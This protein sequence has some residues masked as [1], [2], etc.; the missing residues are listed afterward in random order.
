MKSG[1]RYDDRFRHAQSRADVGDRASNRHNAE[2]ADLDDIV[3]N[4]Y[5]SMH[6]SPSPNSY[7]SRSR[8]R[9][10]DR[11]AWLNVD[12]VQPRGRQS[13]EYSAGREAFASDRQR[14]YRRLLKT[15]PDIHSP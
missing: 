4:G 12:T 11:I 7:A 9:D 3:G 13:G 10:F 6:A 5:R 15:G 1:V 8:H 2:S 14:R